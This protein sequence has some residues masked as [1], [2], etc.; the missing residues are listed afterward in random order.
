[1]TVRPR[2]TSLPLRSCTIDRLEGRILFDA[3]LPTPE[4]QLAVALLTGCANPTAEVTL[5]VNAGRPTWPNAALNE[6]IT[7]NPIDAGAKQPLAINPNLVDAARKHSAWIW[8]TNGGNLSHDE[9][10]AGPG[11]RMVAAGYKFVGNGATWAE[12][13]AKGDLVDQL[14][15]K[16]FADQG[17]AE[18]GHRRN[19]LS[20]GVNEVGVGVFSTGDTTR[21]ETQDFA[22]AGTGS[23][24]TGYA[25]NDLNSNNFYD[26]GEGLGGVSITATRTT[27]NQ[28]FT[29]T[30]WDAG[31]YTLKL[32]PGA[33]VVTASGGNAGTPAPQTITIGT[34]NVEADFVSSASQQAR[35]PVITKQPT[36]AA[37]NLGA[38]ATLTVEVQGSPIPTGQWQISTD[39][40]TTFNDIPGATGLS[41]K[42]TATADVG[43]NKYRVVLTNASGTVTSD[44]TGLQIFGLPLTITQKPQDQTVQVGGTAVFTVAATGATNYKWEYSNG[45]NNFTAVPGG[46]QPTLT[47]PNVTADMSGRLYRVMASNVSAAGFGFA[48][49]NVTAAAVPPTV[50]A[51]PQPATA[52]SG[53][54]ATLTLDTTGTPVPDVQWQTDANVGSATPAVFRPLAVATTFHDVAGL[55]TATVTFPVTAA[56]NNAHYRAVITNSEGSVTTAPVTLKINNKSAVANDLTSLDTAIKAAYTAID[57]C[58]KQSQA[59]IAALRKD[60]RRLKAS[61]AVR[62]Q[63]AN[64]AAVEKFSRGT[65]THNAKAY[66]K[67]LQKLASAV[68]TASAKLKK[69]PAD[70]T[71]QARLTAAI[72]ALQAQV[73]NTSAPQDSNGCSIGQVSALAGLQA[74]APSDPQLR[75]GFV[76]GAKQR[77][78]HLRA[79]PRPGD[80]RPGRRR[81]TDRQCTGVIRFAGRP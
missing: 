34:Q 59:R 19:I 37:V 10:T 28:V 49:L 71:L 22:T 77:Q 55:T 61:K 73:G 42:V 7:K 69:K 52:P 50:V 16:L 79:A 57:S 58:R 74:V 17:I 21:V 38:Q 75:A 47:V 30:T 15:R 80:D 24:L 5:T 6:G 40:G 8:N 81:S 9:G 53:G 66:F 23:F 29:T 46:T 64:V 26:I 32:D 54:D 35:P 62:G 45:D 72:A 65:F 68:G 13:I 18:R 60:L 33:Y 4:E 1:M 78:Q 2:S 12:N 14:H 48:I 67:E 41:Y 27:D 63:L 3:V 70:T 39:G 76:P 36:T 11:Q 20:P 25:I 51:P 44:A 43:T 56:D 31:G